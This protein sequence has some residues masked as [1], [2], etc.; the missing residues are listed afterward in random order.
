MATTFTGLSEA[1]LD[2]I[3]IPAIQAMLPYLGAF[4]TRTRYEERLILNNAYIVPLVGNVTVKDK[5]PGAPV[6]TSGGATGVSVV[7]DKFKGASFYAK[8]GEVPSSLMS[9]WWPEQMKTACVAVA[10]TCV[11][12]ALALITAANYGSGTNDV[13]TQA[14]AQFDDSTLG[15]IHA[16][17]RR[18]LK[19]VRGAFLCDPQVGGK[20]ISMKQM[21]LALA[22]ADD[23][24]SLADG[25]LPGGI[26][27]YDCYEYADFPD[28]SENLVAAVIGRSAIAVAAGAPDQLITS[29][30]GD[31]TYRR[32]FEEP[33]SGL[34]I[35]YTE[36]VNG[37]GKVEAE[38]AQ[39]YGVKK[40]QDAVV[41]L[42]TA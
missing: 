20:L 5:T 2:D 34:T 9:T 32:V 10:Q 1:Q 7:A 3:V 18:K 25:R 12:G 31:V 14:L 13:V 17:A 16:A 30:Q 8:E 26:I 4:S 39:I 38:V 23:R 28:N 11:D 27:G 36:M 40:G 41:R 29:G 37:H 21:V 35:Q 22:V 42:V 15:A 6:E 33:E 24:N 19:N